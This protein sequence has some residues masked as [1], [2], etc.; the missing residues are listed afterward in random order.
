MR[1]WALEVLACPNCGHH[2]FKLIKLRVEAEEIVEGV[3]YCEKCRTWYPIIDGI[4]HLL[5]NKIRESMR[6]HEELNFLRKWRE[7]LPDYIVLE[8]KPYN[9][10]TE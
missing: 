7:K 6:K 9:L 8:G 3:L 10:K 2:P 5:P 1:E 4:P